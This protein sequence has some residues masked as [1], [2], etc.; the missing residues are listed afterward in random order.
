MEEE[1]EGG[2]WLAD[3]TGQEPE[4]LAH[5]RDEGKHLKAAVAA[6]MYGYH[7]QLVKPVERQR[8]REDENFHHCVHEHDDGL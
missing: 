4:E 8:Y 2:G 5:V 7:P 1:G 3:G 6:D